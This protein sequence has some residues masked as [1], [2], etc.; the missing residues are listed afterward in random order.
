MLISRVPGLRS[1]SAFHP[2]M[3]DAGGGAKGGA[4]GV[5]VLVL[6]LIKSGPWGPHYCRL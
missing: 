6:V 3:A 5:T 2:P 4:C 1:Q